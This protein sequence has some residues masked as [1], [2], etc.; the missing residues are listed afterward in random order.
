MRYQMRS[1]VIFLAVLMPL[2]VFGG[3]ASPA[4]TSGC[5]TPK[6]TEKRFTHLINLARDDSSQKRLHLDPELS[7]LARRHSAV[8]LKKDLLHHSPE[9]HDRVTNWS[10]IGENVGVGWSVSSLHEAFM[11]SDGHRKNILYS[12]YRYV[13]VGVKKDG[14]VIWVTVVFEGQSNPGTSLKSAPCS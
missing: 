10:T 11:A 13:G 12:A 4:H 8:M 5:W 1:K 6:H 2:L 7:Y 14:D 3:Y 9:L